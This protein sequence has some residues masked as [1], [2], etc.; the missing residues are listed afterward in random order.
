MKIKNLRLLIIILTISLVIPDFNGMFS[1]DEAAAEG[2]TVLKVIPSPPP[3]EAPAPTPPPVPPSVVLNVYD[4]NRESLPIVQTEPEYDFNAVEIDASKAPPKETQ[5]DRITKIKAKYATVGVVSNAKNRTVEPLKPLELTVE[6]VKM[7]MEQGASVEDVYEVAFLSSITL[8]DPFTLFLDKNK[9]KGSW[10]DFRKSI[11]QRPESATEGVYGAR[12]SANNLLSPSVVANVYSVTDSVY[13]DSI[14]LRVNNTMSVLD[15]NINSVI[16]DY[17]MEVINQTAKPQY[18]DRSYSSELIDPSSGSLTW[19]DTQISLPGRDGLNLDIG[20]VFNS[21]QALLFDPYS[22]IYNYS[23]KKYDLGAGWSFRFPSIETSGWNMYYRGGEGAIYK[24]DF[25]A[26]SSLEQYTHLKGYKGKD[27]QFMFDPNHTNFNGNTSMY[28]LEHSDKTREYFGGNDNS[29]LAIVDRFGNT[30]T[31]KYSNFPTTQSNVVNLL[32]EITDSV[33]RTIRFQYDLINNYDLAKDQDSPE[34]NLIVTV[35]NSA[36]QEDQRVTYTRKRIGFELHTVYTDGSFARY[37]IGTPSPVLTSITHQNGDKTKFGY[38]KGFNFYNTQYKIFNPW[39]SYTESNAY[40]QLNTVQYAH[41]QTQ[42]KYS[43]VKRNYGPQG[44]IGTPRISE[45]YDELLKSGA[46]VGAYNR[47]E[48]KESGSYDAYPTYYE[49]DKYPESYTYSATITQSDSSG[50]I[51]TTELTHNGKGQLLSTDM[52]AAYRERI[53]ERNT[54][55]HSVFTQSPTSSER[56]EYSTAGIIV[57]RLYNETSY[58]EWGN[59]ASA[60]RPMLDSQRSNPAVKLKNTTTFTYEPNF[61]FLSSK[62]WYAS[63]SDTSP[64]SESYTYNAQGRV[65]TTTNAARETTSYTYENASDGSNRLYKMTSEKKAGGVT[66]AKNVITYGSETKYTY[67]TIEEAYSNI[68]Q[69]NQQ[70]LKTTTVY[71]MSN[72]RV[73]EKRDGDQNKTIYSYDTAGR[74]RKETK[75]NRVNANGEVYSDSTEYNYYNQSSGSFDSVN[76]GTWILKVDSINTVTNLSNNNVV[77]TYANVLYNG[78]GLALLEEHWDENAGQWVFTQYHY[79][80]DGR[81]VYSIDPAG[82]TQTVSYDDWGRP[83]RVTNANGDVFVNHYSLIERK[84]TSYIEDKTTGA[85]LNFVE[86]TYDAWGNKISAS[87]YKDW[88]TNTQKITEYYQ[89]NLSGNVTGYTDPNQKLNE[90]GVTTS[91]AYDALG[92]LTTVKDA[93]N[94]T[95]RYSYDGNGKISQVSIQA[96]NGS[97]QTLNTKKYNE[98]G[99]LTTKQDS[100]SKSESYMYNNLGQLKV[101]TDRNG[102]SF[103]YTYDEYGQLKK[104]VISG[105]INNVA[106]TQEI[107]MIYG[108]GT[109]RKQTVQTRTNNAVTATQTLTVD[110]LGQVRAN[111]S[112]A[113]GHSALMENQVDVVGRLKQV[114]DRYMLFY[115]N[116]Q[117]NNQRL[118]KVQTD[119]SSTIN[120]SASSN[121]Q[122]EYLANN[123]VK[124]ITYPTLA[125]GSILKTEY[126]RN[127]AMGWTESLSNKRGSYVLSSFTYSYDNN[128]NQLSVSESR[129]GGTKKTTNY[130]YDALNRLLSISKPDGSVTTYSYDLQGNRQTMSNTGG[131]ILDNT[132]INYNYDLQNTLTSVTKGGVAT[133][134]Q[135]YADGLR[136]MKTNGNTQT[137]VNYNFQ[138][139][140]ISEEKIVSGEFVEQANFVRGDRILVKKDRK[141]TKDYYYLYNGHGDVIQIVDTSGNVVN[142]YVY[143]EWGTITSQTEGITNSFKYAGES[144]DSETGLYYQRARYYDPSMGRFINEDTYEGQIDNPLSQNVYTYVHNNPLIYSDPSGNYCVSADSNNTHAGSCSST[145]QKYEMSD[146][147]IQDMPYI[148]NGVLRGYYRADGSIIWL[149]NDE[150]TKQSFWQF[151]TKSQYQEYVEAVPLGN[152]IVTG[153]VSTVVSLGQTFSRLTNSNSNRGGCNCFVEGTKVLT[154]EGEK[155]IE[156]IDVGDKVL[157]KSEYD[158]NGE[159]AY[160]EVTALYRNQRDDIIKLHVGKQVIETTDNHPFWVEG[161]GW[162]F[163]DE[164]QVG[165]KLQKADGNNLTIDKLEFVKLDKP[166]T[167]YN[168]TVADFHTYYVTDLGVWVHNTFCANVTKDMLKSNPSMFSGKSVDEIANMMRESGYNITVQA[169]TKSSSGAI[170]IKVHNTGNG[171]NI[172]QVQVSPG[173]GTHGANPYVKISTSDQ[174]IIK[175]VQGSSSNYVNNHQGIE[176]ATIIFTGD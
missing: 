60:T 102:S 19:K 104:S 81:P 68:G 149:S 154:D 95:T 47:L 15:M 66:V 51:T 116:Y 63:E 48:Y 84:N 21:N 52:K 75:P 83:Y 32:S 82:N 17:K 162:V 24:I 165:D 129:N 171:K 20:V 125:G 144:Y 4:S 103:T 113:G 37:W 110:S 161:K 77:R 5:A 62:S 126:T 73:L 36:G 120:G 74:L 10:D 67:P 99:L 6:Q 140:V 8:I 43:Y 78:L 54:S 61:H 85:K 22:G 55:F 92:R 41:S 136:F 72:G 132:E 156:E 7:L 11:S 127:M 137:Q 142:N 56:W 155:P 131:I 80:N 23:G 91:Y 168:F 148:K 38:S 164:L 71:D 94:Q 146:A 158:A 176:N 87:T 174:G 111:Y 64:L 70:I 130:T 14:N 13:N 159:L 96:K 145:S 59:V 105:K 167:V 40:V 79:D 30:I 121:V 39:D 114:S 50:R 143:D 122:Y 65:L 124:S 100:A 86:D 138:G 160:K 93:L 25:A 173:G 133:S 1:F 35:L 152:M 150:T 134:F 123:Q 28:Y 106:Q 147:I 2:K 12:E 128:G 57:N 76:S 169:S 141:K 108:D 53:V 109:P 170:I 135:Y 44:S 115:T 163:A 49:E 118:E 112:V 46:F 27:M 31:F 90:D 34:E 69:S 119:G 3:T 9:I 16:N 175:I 45:R 98:L 139:E 58:D 153:A 89:Y 29:L 166:V 97:P 172:T 18:S 157:A 33:G 101:K 88:P 42:Y 117:Y 151:M 107:S 26:T